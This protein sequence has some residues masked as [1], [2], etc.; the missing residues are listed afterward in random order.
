MTGKTRWIRAVGLL[1]GM[2]LL[3]TGCTKANGGGWI[4]SA[5][6]SGKATFGFNGKCKDTTLDG[7]PAAAISGQVQYKDAP[8]GVYFHGTINSTVQGSTC[9]EVSDDFDAPGSSDFFGAYR[10][11]P[12]GDSG[13]F[14]LTVTDNG[15][16]GI[17][18]DG[19][20]IQLVDG[21]YSGYSNSGP[22]QGGNIQVH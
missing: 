18:G 21:L 4:V 7:K 9:A 2:A 8:A 10:P 3:L 15:E 6:G 14:L 17:N 1:I 11:Q 19:I 13:T 22:I 16:P 20:A 12:S 5:T